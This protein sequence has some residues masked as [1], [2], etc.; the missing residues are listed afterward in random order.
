MS[1]WKKALR[2]VQINIEDRYSR[3]LTKLSGKDLI[4][5]IKE[6]NANVLVLFAR[7]PWGRKFYSSNHYQHPKLKYD[8]IKE[9]INEAHKENIK[10][11]V[12]VAHTANKKVFSEHSEWAQVNYKGEV[13]LLEHAPKEGTYI[14][15][16]PQICINSP[17][18]NM[19]KEEVNEAVNLGADG[20][21]LDS[22][23]YQPDFERACY[24]VWCQRMFKDEKGYEMPRE[25]NWSDSRWK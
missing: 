20:V 11:I 6:L 22:F 17:Y 8:L 25:P 2:V 16:W 9:V 15:E 3:Y 4:K 23:R 24:C 7:D 21:F 10:V 1:W 5:I 13:I 19:L 18:F 14:P 12:M